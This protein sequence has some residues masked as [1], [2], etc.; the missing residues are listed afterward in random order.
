MKKYLV[1]LCLFTI[2]SI[3]CAQKEKEVQVLISTEYGDIKLK[4]YNETPK[5]RDNFVKLAK[6]GFYDGTLFHRII[7]GFM[8]QGGDPQSKN[9]KPGQQL[10][11]GGPGYTI[12]AEFNPEFIHKKGAL[13]AARMGD[14]V[15]PK[16]ESSGSQFY[17]VQ[18]TVIPKEKLLEFGK[19]KGI[20]FTEE[21][22]TA[23]TT[24]GGSPHLDTQ[25]TVY[26]EVVEGL[27][28]ID[29]IAE[30]PRDSRD[31]PIK[32]ISITVKVLE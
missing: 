28:V 12:P 32:D 13:S 16:R 8:I 24:I 5:H 7:K 23:Y 2:C 4:L 20:T 31:R 3:S 19:S 26:G 30:V 1:I 25:Y 21:Q 22:I 6:E 27:E 17:I 9:A 15:N 29:K 18:G 14:N 10:G 11:N